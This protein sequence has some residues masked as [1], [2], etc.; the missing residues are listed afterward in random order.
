MEEEEEDAVQGGTW[1]R[2]LV[3]RLPKVRLTPGVAFTLLLSLAV[4]A[5][6]LLRAG[7][8]EDPAARLD[9]EAGVLGS[10]SVHRLITYIYYHEDLSSLA[11]S[12]LIAWYFGGGFEENSGTIKFCFLTPLFA[13][14][15]GLMYLAI[16]ATGFSPQVDGRVQGFTSVAF[17]MITVFTTRTSLR[18]LLFFGF[19][20][21]TKLLPLLFLIL[22]MFIPHAP[23]LSNACS[24]LVGVA[25]GLGG[26]FFLDPPE[27]LL[28]R[29]DQML[30]FKLLKRIPVL[31]YI[32]AS[33][34][35]RSASSTRKLNPPPG[36]YPTQPYY[37]PPLELPATYTHNVQPAGTWHH[38]GPRAGSSTYPVGIVSEASL[39]KNH[40]CS[41]GHSHTDTCA[42]TNTTAGSVPPLEQLLQVQTQ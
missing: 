23:V 22:A 41:V 38:S 1:R 28:S 2:S 3:S 14:S 24:I 11:C 9:L 15:S 8:G 17:T 31:N 33:S 6:A 36:S 30:T 21:P 16:L 37:T 20:V 12:C 10:M 29:M 39:Q 27:S 19:M 25:Y 26:C 32:P 5:P 35:E 7:G 18:R 34:V 42:S 13:V 40:V 4:S